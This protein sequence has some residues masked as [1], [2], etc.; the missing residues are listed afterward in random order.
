MLWDHHQY[1]PVS[2]LKVEIAF[3]LDLTKQLRLTGKVFPN[4]TK[5]I[6]VFIFFLPYYT[7]EVHHR[8]QLPFSDSSF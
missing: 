5:S 7:L 4:L 1:Q 3:E 6:H 8:H 2:A